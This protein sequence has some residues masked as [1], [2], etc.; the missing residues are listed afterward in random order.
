MA[1]NPEQLSTTPTIEQNDDGISIHWDSDHSS[2]FHYF[3]L[4]SACHCDLCG[5][6][7]TGSR[8][9]HPSNVPVDIK[10]IAVTIDGQLKITWQPDRHASEYAFAWL[11]KYAYDGEFRQPEW[12]HDLWDGSLEL[13]QV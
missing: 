6:S 9:L 5:D 4:R 8:R 12:H 11:R 2:F 7:Y 3:W 10:P 1:T 13:E